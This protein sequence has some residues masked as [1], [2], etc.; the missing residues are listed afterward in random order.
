MDSSNQYH[1]LLVEPVKTG[2]MIVWPDGSE[3]SSQ[4]YKRAQDARREITLLRSG[5]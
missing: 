2:Y 3:F 1:Q 4:V 5:K